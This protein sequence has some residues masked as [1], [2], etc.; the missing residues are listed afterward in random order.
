M[1]DVSKFPE[2]ITDVKELGYMYTALRRSS[3]AAESE[4]QEKEVR[5]ARRVCILW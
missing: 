1:F 3:V 4:F 2:H 5:V